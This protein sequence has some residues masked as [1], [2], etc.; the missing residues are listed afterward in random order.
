M[1]LDEVTQATMFAYAEGKLTLEQLSAAGKVNACATQGLRHRGL[2]MPGGFENDRYSHPVGAGEPLHAVESGA[3]ARLA[4][5]SEKRQGPLISIFESF[6]GK[7]MCLIGVEV[8]I[9]SELLH[10]AQLYELLTVGKGNVGI[11]LSVEDQKRRHPF[12]LVEELIGQAAVPLG[13]RIHWRPLGA[14]G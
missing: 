11:A 10:V 6:A 7:A 9:A 14:R 8:V 1:V 13:N 2:D 12:H 5:R 3:A 4:D